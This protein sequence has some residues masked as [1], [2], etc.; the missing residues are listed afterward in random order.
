MHFLDSM[1]FTHS[2]ESDQSCAKTRV[3]RLDS[4]KSKAVDGISSGI[5]EKVLIRFM[6]IQAYVKNARLDPCSTTC[7]FLSVKG[8]IR[9]KSRMNTG[10]SKRG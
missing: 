6:T 3:H 2:I 9:K 4:F 1:N 10:T 7:F 8:W 5:Q